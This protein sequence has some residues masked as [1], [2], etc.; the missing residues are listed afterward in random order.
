MSIGYISSRVNVREPFRQYGMDEAW[1]QYG[2]IDR[3][4]MVPI[5]ILHTKLSDDLCHVLVKAHV[6]TG[7]DTVSKVGSKH[8]A[9]VKT[10]L[11]YLISWGGGGGGG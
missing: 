8:A 7:D 5:H 6:L 4:R 9:V 10:P 11:A 2:V 1:M 3:R